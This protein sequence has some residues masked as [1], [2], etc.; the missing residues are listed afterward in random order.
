LSF[1]CLHGLLLSFPTRRSSD[2]ADLAWLEEGTK[3]FNEYIA[4]L[5]W[6]QHFALLNREEMMDRVNNQLGRW[7]GEPVKAIQCINSHH[8]FTDRKSTRLNSSHVSIS[9]AVFC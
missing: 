3:A 2:L 1:N 5:R 9:Y 7:A 8:N 4:Q 6:A